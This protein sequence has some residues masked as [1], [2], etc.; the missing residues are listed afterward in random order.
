MAVCETCGNDYARSFTVSRNGDSWTFDSI[1]C[2]ASKLAP[3]CAHCGCRVLGHGVEATGTVYCCAN[4]ARMAGHD[5]LV[6]SA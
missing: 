2:A 3:S 5:E 6:D 4:C 1:E